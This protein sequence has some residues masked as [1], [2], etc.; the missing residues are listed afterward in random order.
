MIEHP[1]AAPVKIACVPVREELDEIVATMLA[2]ALERGGYQAQVISVSSVDDMVAAASRSGPDIVCLS[3]L[4]PFVM[5][6]ARLLCDKL[7]AQIPQAQI[8][9][10][11][12][13]FS[14]DLKLAS[15]RVGIQ[16]QDGLFTRLSQIVSFIGA[17]RQKL[18][19]S[20]RESTPVG[21]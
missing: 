15:R 6:R 4:S 2:H 11:L 12:W 10:G 21:L 13:G 3:A 7:H 19:V 16:G 5:S 14:G 20:A 9:V 8:I 18:P 1:Y 17:S